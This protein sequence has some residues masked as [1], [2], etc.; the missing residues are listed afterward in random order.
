MFGYVGSSAGS[1][2]V[3]D[4]SFGTILALY[5]SGVYTILTTTISDSNA[6]LINTTTGKTV[7]TL[8]IENKINFYQYYLYGNLF[9]GMEVGQECI[10][11]IYT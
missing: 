11:E 4:G 3:L 5:N 1:C 6:Q 2:E 9:E 10:V 7:K 8:E